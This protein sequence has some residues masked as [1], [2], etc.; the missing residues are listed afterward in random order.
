M[1]S[2]RLRELA[3]KEKEGKKQAQ[4]EQKRAY[5]EETS[6][7]LQKVIQ[8]DKDRNAKRNRRALLTEDKKKEITEKRRLA[9]KKGK[10]EISLL[11]A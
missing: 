3:E 5:R 6:S 1:R 9:Y 11:L 4:N 10:K 7:S 8:L 2:P